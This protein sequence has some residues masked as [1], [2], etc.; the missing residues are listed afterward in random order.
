[1]LSNHHCFDTGKIWQNVHT[2]RRNKTR[3]IYVYQKKKKRG[4]GTLPQDTP[5]SVDREPS[6]VTYWVCPVKKNSGPIVVIYHMF[7]MHNKSF[8]L[9]LK[10]CTHSLIC[11]GYTSLSKVVHSLKKSKGLVWCY[12][13][14]FIH[15]GC[16]M[17]TTS[18]GQNSGLNEFITWSWGGGAPGN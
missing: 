1:M 11:N 12:A 13:Q 7:L 18:R 5:T 3:T 2:T 8:L 14:S 9:D 16:H 10:L 15:D 4:S 17:D 6:I